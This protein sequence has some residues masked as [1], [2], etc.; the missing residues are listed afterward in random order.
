MHEFTLP[1]GPQHPAFAEPIHFRLKVDGESVV[2]AEM[3]LGYNHRG[4]EK[5][6]ESR[7]WF[8]GVFLSGRICGICSQS[9]TACYTQGIEKLSGTTVPDRGRFIRTI[10]AELERIHSHMLLLAVAGHAIGFDTAFHYI[11]RDREY[12]LGIMELVSGKRVQHDFNTIGGVRWDI[13]EEHV[14]KIDNN[15]NRIEERARHYLK[16]FRKDRAIRKRLKGVGRLSKKDA[17]EFGVVGPV[18]RASGITSDLRTTGYFAYGDIPFNPIKGEE[19]DCMERMVVRLKEIEQSVRIIRDCLSNLP[20]G[21]TKANL[22]LVINIEKGKEATSRVEAPRGELFYYIKSAGLTPERVKIRT[23]TYANF[24]CIGKI[25][26][27]TQI[28]DAPITIAS[29]DPCIACCDRM[30]IVDVNTGKEKVLDHHEIEHLY[31][32]EHKH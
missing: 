21:E 18:A 4:I 22:P 11:W 16:V 29:L 26:E 1:V 23:P 9:H 10:F 19:G 27:G 15:L 32:K 31:G 7:Q 3:H 28:A 25:L 2:D 17:T 5:A 14:R 8:K 20:K 12:C 6:L 13:A 30:T 24:S